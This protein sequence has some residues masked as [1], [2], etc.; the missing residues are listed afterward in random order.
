M[1]QHRTSKSRNHRKTVLAVSVL[2]AIAGLVA[3]GAPL[4]SAGQDQ[5][6]PRAAV[7]QSLDRL[8]RDDGFPGA[9]ASLRDS[10]GNFR[11][12]TAGVGDLET[13]SKVP[14]DGQVRIASTSKLYTATVVLQLVGEGRID[15]DAS[16]ETYLPG[17]VR[18][19]GIDGRKITVRQLLQHTSGLPD[20]TATMPDFSKWRN[21]YV[22]AHD[23]LDM[24]LK[25]KASFAPGNGWEYSNTNYTVA[26]LIVQ[27]VTGRPIGEEITNR[28]VERIG[29]RH[30]YWP[31]AGDRSIRE[32]H[33]HGYASDTPGGPLSDA[34]EADPSWG[35]AAGQ[36]IARPSDVNR[37]LTALMD[38]E[39]LKPRQLKEM[40]TTVPAKGLPDGWRYGLGIVEMPLS[41]GGVAW[42]HGGDF[43]GYENRNGVTDD[44]RAA[45]VAVTALPSGVQA[46]EHVNAALDTALCAR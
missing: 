18:G 35:G 13:R 45:T 7:Q 36:I 22:T 29:L 4:A 19:E 44:G 25:E 3:V 9:L 34:T 12:Y 30:T 24:A 27:K 42:G 10:K 40:R 2:G 46:A 32:R 15:L 17:L 8:V 21:T 38:G 28:I 37:F 16:V 43:D 31:G 33:P 26:G 14:V 41:C 23:L 39:L 20:Y 5:A 11:N 1:V 6:K